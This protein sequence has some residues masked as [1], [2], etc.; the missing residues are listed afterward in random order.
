MTNAVTNIDKWIDL[1]LRNPRATFQVSTHNASRLWSLGRR[2][3]VV[4][5]H[6]NRSPW[7]P[8]LTLV[9]RFTVAGESSRTRMYIFYRP[10]ATLHFTS[11]SRVVYT[12]LLIKDLFRSYVPITNINTAASCTLIIIE[13]QLSTSRHLLMPWLSHTLTSSQ[14]PDYLPTPWLSPKTLLTNQRK[15]S[16]KVKF[17]DFHPMWH[18]GPGFTDS[19]NLRS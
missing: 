9:L 17:P 8:H 5:L 14:H 12:Q 19:Q 7:R 2:I 6:S 4:F 18:P 3:A 13:P 15:W 1:L 11:C 10:A 16:K